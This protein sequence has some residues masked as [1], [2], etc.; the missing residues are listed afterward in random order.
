MNVNGIWML[1]LHSFYFLDFIS[2]R[3]SRASSPWSWRYHFLL[4]E[5]LRVCLKPRKP[6]QLVQSR[7]STF[8]PRSQISKQWPTATV[9][10]C[11]ILNNANKVVMVPRQEKITRL[12]TTMIT[13]DMIPL[14]F[15]EEDDFRVLIAV[16]VPWSTITVSG[17][18]LQWEIS[19]VKGRVGG[20]R[21][22]CSHHQ[23]M[24]SS[25]HWIVCDH[26]P[27]PVGER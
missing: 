26:Y 22:C 8:C 24:D 3:S 11:G 5:V 17:E 7:F 27:S 10:D 2:T 4:V 13:K 9:Q 15:V 6:I 14:N 19:Q 20:S 1:W 21:V 25:H 12:I 16:V 23:F 18:N